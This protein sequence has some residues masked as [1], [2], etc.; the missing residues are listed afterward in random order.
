M[1]SAVTCVAFVCRKKQNSTPLLQQT[2]LTVG[3]GSSKA[4]PPVQ[5]WPKLSA[6]KIQE[7]V[8]AIALAL[9]SCNLPLGLLEH[10]DVQDALLLMAP[11]MKDHLC[12]VFC[13]HYKA[14]YSCP[15]VLSTTQQPFFKISL[16]HKGGSG[17]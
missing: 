7:R 14:V 17:L 15:A 10:G 5:V 2:K 16:K 8:E 11:Y 4:A 13:G 9:Y 3:A 6:K 1:A 12:K